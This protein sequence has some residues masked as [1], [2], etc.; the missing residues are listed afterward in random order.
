ME[1][2]IAIIVFCVIIT[3]HELG[4]FVVAKLCGI[5][6]KEFAIGMGPAL[7]KWKGKETQ[8]SL[9][10]F[11]IG[12]YCNMEG[13]DVSSDDERAF[14]NKP[15]YQRMLVTC[16][17]AV[18]NIALGF[19]VVMLQTSTGGNIVSTTIKQFEENATS[20][21]SGLKVD[22]KILKVNGMNIFVDYDIVYQ[23][24]SD[25][26]GL[27][28]MQV[29][30]DGEK[31]TL[32][33]VHFAIEKKADNSQSI[34]IDFSV[35]STEKT[36]FNVIGQSFKETASTARLIWISLGDLITG[37][38]G[39]ND[40][41]GPVGV[42]SAIGQASSMGINTLLMLISFI[43]IN[44]GIFNLL[45]IPAL[46]GG[47]M[48]FLIIEAIRRKPIKPEHEGY[49]HFIGFALLILLIIIISI[50]DIGMLISNASS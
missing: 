18:M 45:P 46:D 33:D 8:Y 16:A 10:L 24:V 38:Y 12:G 35:Y 25:E 31:V 50:K 14:C 7:I 1:I 15:V 36:F 17:G 11:P 5:Y 23:L 2:L 43:T 34:N 42:V 47:R 29:L 3:V 49:V 32:K 6:V 22:D 30:R 13:E 9:R 41:S 40:L 19:L 27:V 20:A 39:I 48:I 4:H 37:K 26:D 21:Q 44:V 28:D